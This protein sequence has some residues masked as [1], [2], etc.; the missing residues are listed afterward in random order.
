MGGCEQIKPAGRGRKPPL[1]RSEKEKWK[2]REEKRGEVRYKREGATKKD[3]LTAA[4]HVDLQRGEDANDAFQR[5]MQLAELGEGKILR[6]RLNLAGDGRADG[7][8]F[9]HAGGQ[10]HNVHDA[11]VVFV[12]ADD[13]RSP[14]RTGDPPAG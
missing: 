7:S 9:L 1:L 4:V 8:E 11:A 3:R 6:L 13:R 10:D 2:N 5:I 12:A 14:P